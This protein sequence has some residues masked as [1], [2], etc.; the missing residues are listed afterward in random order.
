MSII[1][2]KYIIQSLLFQSALSTVYLGV[3]KTT[4]QKVV[5]KKLASDSVLKA[6]IS[7]LKQLNHPNIVRY[8]DSFEESGAF[9]IVNEYFEG[10]PLTQVSFSLEEWLEVFIAVLK[11]VEYIHKRGLIHRDIKPQNILISTTKEVKIIDFGT[12]LLQSDL[13]ENDL[14]ILGTLPY[15]SPEQTGYLSSPIT[16]KTDIYSLGV[17]FYECL[18]GSNPFLGKDKKEIIHKHL[19]LL[20]KDLTQ[21]LQD[22]TNISLLD[23]INIIIQKMILKEP[24]KRYADVSTILTAFEKLYEKTFPQIEESSVILRQSLFEEI[25]TYIKES[26]LQEKKS[27]VLLKGKSGTGKNFLL[28]RLYASI[29]KQIDCLYLKTTGVDFYF[30]AKQIT[31]KIGDFDLEKKDLEKIKLP[32]LF[33]ENIQRADEPSMNLLI[34]NPSL[35]VVAAYD[36]EEEVQNS[37]LVEQPTKTFEI[38]PYSKKEIEDFI[39]ENFGKKAVISDKLLSK[40]FS[41][42]KGNIDVLIYL[43]KLFYH[44]EALSFEENKW[45]FKEEEHIFSKIT[46][47]KILEFRVSE[48][49]EKLKQF[50]QELAVYGPSFNLLNLEKLK[51]LFSIKAKHIDGLLQEAKQ[52][53][54]LENEGDYYHFVNNRIFQ[55]FYDRLEPFER[56]RKH[57]KIANMILKI[58]DFIYPDGPLFFHF[59]KAGSLKEALLWGFKLINR[60]IGQSAYAKAENTFDDIVSI[61][62][63]Y[64]NITSFEKFQFL[65]ILNSMIRVFIVSGKYDEI[66]VLLQKQVAELYKEEEYKESLIEIYLNLGRLYSL[67]G[68]LKQA[69]AQYFMAEQEALKIGNQSLLKDLY[70]NIATNSLFSSNFRKAIFYYEK[71][72]QLYRGEDFKRAEVLTLKGII[73]YS[74]AGLGDYEKAY[75]ALED[76]ESFDVKDKHPSYANTKLHYKILVL[77]HIGDVEALDEYEI[78]KAA[79]K[80]KDNEDLL[81]YSLLFSIGYYYYRSKKITQA[82]DSI[83]ASVRLGEKLKVEVGIVAPYLLLAEISI[84]LKK[85]RFAQSL[86]TKIK[87]QIKKNKDFFSYQWYLRLK[88]LF[89]SHSLKADLKKAELLLKKAIS[90]AQKSKLYT[91]VARNYYTYSKV[92]FNFGELDKAFSLEEKSLNLF[93]SLKMHWE[94]QEARS[95]LMS[96]SMQSSQSLLGEKI[97]LEALSNLSTLISKQQNTSELL[98]AIME[99]AIEIGA[100][101][102]GGLFFKNE[103]D[104][105]LVYNSG[106]DK[107]F[108]I[109]ENILESIQENNEPLLSSYKE[110]VAYVYLPISFQNRFQG[111]IYLE[112]NLLKNIFNQ[113]QVRILK[114][115]STLFG[116]LIENA[117]AY[118]ALESEKENLERKVK[119]R[120][121]EVYE[122]N[123]IIEEDLNAAR[124]FQRNLMPGF[125]PNM[126]SLRARIIYQPLE[127]I[128]GDYYDFIQIS[129]NKLLFILADVSGHGIQS[130]FLTAMLK[131]ALFTYPDSHYLSLQHLMRHINHSLYGQIMEKYL[132]CLVGLIDIEKNEIKMVGGGNISVYRFSFKEQD[133]NKVDI[134]GNMLGILPTEVLNFTEESFSFSENDRLFITTDGVVEE[135]KR[136]EDGRRIFF[137]EQKLFEVLKKQTDPTKTMDELLVELGQFSKKEKFSDDITAILFWRT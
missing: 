2:E 107:N 81:S 43:L 106:L 1:K 75:E 96:Y 12:S 132:V 4:S 72:V 105:K 93:Q 134:K 133:W 18:S 9:F 15:M 58:K 92:C 71:A 86:F 124:V 63:N 50:L 77:S 122:R 102:K 46:E 131:T 10:L 69:Q 24:E 60:L 3:E 62:K 26:F 5:I 99:L 120:T 13:V 119:E 80:I 51:G 41:F 112:N 29:K 66:I 37:F 16:V 83:F 116:V 23:K 32:V 38:K 42:C 49:S 19:S 73:A 118:K 54:I 67:K 84:K 45:I 31:H 103:D 47:E 56:Q 36:E 91:E 117:R 17:M 39:K 52:E 11:G 130:S 44:Q 57:L 40:I 89:F 104:L 114:I 137:G 35:H 70:E 14:R 30:L 8:I 22:E 25:R 21:I 6:E 20:P 90:I 64:P 55:F 78:E 100:A 101:N 76:L 27:I 28:E 113:E 79:K 129:E 85:F 110:N 128:G 53:S 123:Q 82:F 65:K 97:K 88:A 125:L 61:Y 126:Q 48:L 135:Y 109:S 94:E 87:Q 98:K 136:A 34:Q 115:L 121:K 33:I 111:V 95:F 108:S 68:E 7:F 127:S 59:Y 74:Y